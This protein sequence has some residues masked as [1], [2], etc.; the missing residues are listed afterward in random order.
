MAPIAALDQMKNATPEQMQKG[1]DMWKTWSDA[2]KD[3]IVEM[4]APL[5]STKSVSSTGV[6]D[7]KNE[8]CGYTIVQADSPEAAAAVFFAHPH[9]TMQGVTIDVLACL[10][11]S[12]KK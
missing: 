12:D 7:T 9:L 5:G 2:H 6:T 3:A 4:G 11:M 1:M 8:V 10:D